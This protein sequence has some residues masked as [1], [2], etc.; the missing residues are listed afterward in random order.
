MAQ[1]LGHCRDKIDD[2]S[3][4]ILMYSYLDALGSLLRPRSASRT[5]SGNFKRFVREFMLDGSALSVN[6]DELW[7][8]RCG[9]LHLF[10][11]D[12][13]HNNGT[14]KACRKIVYVGSRD[15]AQTAA[16]IARLGSLTDVVFIDPWDLFNPFLAAVVKFGKRVVKDDALAHDV[17]HH[18][19]KMFRQFRWVMPGGG[20][21]NSP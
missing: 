20:K 18:A 19:G 6:E 8:A 17:L 4:L 7:A 9:L 3:A 5:N 16:E 21:P 13:D 2:M 15:Q 1:S 11:P 10:S 12:S 14:A